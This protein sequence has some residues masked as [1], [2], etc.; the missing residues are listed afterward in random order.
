M[1]RRKFTKE[2]KEEA[3]KL[4]RQQGLKVAAA[5]RDLRISET[6]LHNWLRR[7]CWFPGTARPRESASVRAA[8]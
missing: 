5:A 7:A 6:T 1:Q 8:E 4:V 3:V 2:F